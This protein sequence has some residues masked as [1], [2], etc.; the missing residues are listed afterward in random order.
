MARLKVTSSDINAR[1]AKGECANFRNN[2]CQGR[3]PCAV[4]S[5]EACEYFSTYVKP[6]LEYPDFSAKYGREAKI[7]VALNP[8]AKVI[9]KRQKAGEPALAL[10]NEPAA[11]PAV[12]KTT[13][14]AKEPP[15]AKEPAS[16]RI[17]AKTVT[18]E[19]VTLPALSA[20]PAA[21]P[22]KRAVVMPEATPSTTPAMVASAPVGELLFEV[23]TTAPKRHKAVAAS[24]PAAVADSATSA[25]PATAKPTPSI[26]PAAAPEVS[27][28][29]TRGNGKELL[30]EKSPDAKP[31]APPAPEQPQ[32][33]ADLMPAAPAGTRHG[34]KR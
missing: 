16:P 15:Q 19:P 7:A 9:R 31:K 26:S 24:Q 11:A 33:F 27:R 13:K 3:T 34:R 32:L 5:A 8:K 2:C 22:R 29:L 30:A 21:P 1:L 28:N 6:L 23:A 17:A 10:A 25:T 20:T 12:V 4:V 14:P 18:P